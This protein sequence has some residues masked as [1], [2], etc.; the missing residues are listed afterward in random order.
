[1]NVKLRARNGQSQWDLDDEADNALAERLATQSEPV[2]I[3]DDMP[4]LPAQPVAKPA[5]KPQIQ[6]SSRAVE[7]QR[8]HAAPAAPTTVNAKELIDVIVS[9]YMANDQDR[10]TIEVRGNEIL[11]EQVVDQDG[12]KWKHSWAV[13]IAHYRT[14]SRKLIR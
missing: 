6:R 2:E 11:I 3:G 12:Q 14:A 4:V 1:M 5:A 7:P 13:G 9:A 8:T 10:V